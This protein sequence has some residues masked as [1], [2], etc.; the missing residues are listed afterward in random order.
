MRLGNR[1]E[2]ALS[3]GFSDRAN[4]ASCERKTWVRLKAQSVVVALSKE[5][6]RMEIY[7]LKEV[8]PVGTSQFERRGL[9]SC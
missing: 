2:D 9:K 7:N 8:T 5:V 4:V 6:N 3:F 1:Q